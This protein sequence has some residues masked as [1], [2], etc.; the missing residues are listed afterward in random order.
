M[1]DESEYY[2]GDFVETIVNTVEGVLLNVV[3][4]MELPPKRSK[5]RIR[6]DNFL[7]MRRREKHRQK[8][9]ERNKNIDSLI[10]LKEAWFGAGSVEGDMAILQTPISF[11]QNSPT[12]TVPL[13]QYP[14]SISKKWWG[15]GSDL[16]V[17][18]VERIES[19]LQPSITEVKHKPS[20]EF[21]PPQIIESIE[22]GLMKEE[23]KNFGRVID[24]IEK[25][26]PKISDLIGLE[27]HTNIFLDQDIELPEW[28]TTII[29]IKV[30]NKTFKEKME[31]WDLCV[32]RISQVISE[33]RDE[34][35]KEGGDTSKVDDIDKNLYIHFDLED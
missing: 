13:F 33:T 16:D 12:S 11:T 5:Y 29:E 2:T 4:E 8:V 9:D 20:S 1:I 27:Y 35:F 34:I 28:K 22:V 7:L 23:D 19:R 6:M 21:E 18:L 15:V 30:E 26:I 24:N 10:A 17:G 3:A 32:K 25:I 14:E 31:L